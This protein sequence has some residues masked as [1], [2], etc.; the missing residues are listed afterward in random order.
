MARSSGQGRGCGRISASRCRFDAPALP[1]IARPIRSLIAAAQRE[2]HEVAA[3]PCVD[4]VET[5][6]DKL[7]A[8]AW[9]VRA[10]AIAARA[11]DDPTIIRHLHDLAALEQ[12]AA[13]AP[14]FREL[15]MAAVAADDR[16]GRGPAAD[17]SDVRRDAAAA[18]NR[19]FMG[20]GI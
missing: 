9:R 15:V 17:P 18:R 1:P 19:S 12:L 8:L 13:V 14:R 20:A 7:S 10:R 2:P 6:A 16:Q 4:P 3:F 11:N 5:A